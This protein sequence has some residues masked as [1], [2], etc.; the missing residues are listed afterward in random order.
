VI[1]FIFTPIFLAAWSIAAT[2]AALAWSFQQRRIT[3]RSHRWLALTALPGLLLLVTFFSLAVHMHSRL[4]GWPDFYGTDGLPLE[5]VTHSSV[6][7]WVFSIVLLLALCMPLVLAL[8]AIVPQLRTG[9]IYPA[10]CAATSWLC[11]FMTA[12]APA[13]FQRWWWD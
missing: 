11:L 5:L 6:S 12:L 7:E 3:V 2:I 10:S 4:G 9:M 1:S 13:G 8:F